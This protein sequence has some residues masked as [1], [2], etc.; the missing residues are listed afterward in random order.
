MSTLSE[1]ANS[2]I[3]QRNVNNNNIICQHG[4]NTEDGRN[5][6]EDKPGSIESDQSVQI[7]DEDFPI[8]S[9]S[10]SPETNQDRQVRSF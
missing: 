5:F 1:I 8:L 7:I 4:K 10:A 9:S 3:K 6:I 2:L